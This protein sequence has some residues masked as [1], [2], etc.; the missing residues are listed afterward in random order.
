MLAQVA[1]GAYWWEWV[2]RWRQEE[3]EEQQQKVVVGLQQ[4]GLQLLELQQLSE[5]PLK[6][7]AKSWFSKAIS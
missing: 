1:Q 3:V 6:I 5:H 2:P 4:Q 7:Q